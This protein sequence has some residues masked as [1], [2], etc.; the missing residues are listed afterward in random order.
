LGFP[1]AQVIGV[2]VAETEPLARRA[3]KA[4]KVMYE[5]LPAVISIEDAIAADSYYEKYHGDSLVS[6]DL[7]AGFAGARGLGLFNNSK[8]IVYHNCL[9]KGV[10]L[11]ML[12]IDS[13][14]LRPVGCAYAP[15]LRVLLQ[16]L[17][18]WG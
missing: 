8:Y 5:D 2:V 7:E 10:T 14:H 17:K 18:G 15:L 12:V 4:V 9:C 16:L 13:C 6:G 1:L 3:A 11:M